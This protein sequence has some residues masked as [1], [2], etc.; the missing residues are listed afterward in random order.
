MRPEVVLKT[1]RTWKKCTYGAIIYSVMDC[2]TNERSQNL[3]KFMEDTAVICNSYR[4]HQTTW[5][6]MKSKLYYLKDVLFVQCHIYTMY[7]E[8]G[9]GRIGK[10][11]H[12]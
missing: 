4:G 12:L 2:S 5:I 9:G 7:N 11:W 3:E 1:G 6:R 10:R 8:G